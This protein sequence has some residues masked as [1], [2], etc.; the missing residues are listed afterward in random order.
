MLVS[1][2]RPARLLF[3]W[4]TVALVS[5]LSSRVAADVS[6]S[7]GPD[8]PH[9]T[10]R[11]AYNPGT[12]AEDVYSRSQGTRFSQLFPN[13]I[14]QYVPFP[15]S[16]STAKDFILGEL[17]DDTSQI[18]VFPLD[19][20][21]PGDMADYL[22]D[23][24]QYGVEAIKETIQ[25]EI[26]ANNS[27]KGRLVSL[28]WYSD[29]GLLY[30]RK[31]LLEQYNFTVPQTW[32][33]LEA[34]ALAILAGETAAGRGTN[35]IGFSFQ[36]KSYEGLTCN[37]LEWVAGRGGGEFVQLAAD[38]VTA[39]LT[40]NNPVTVEALETMRRFLGTIS[41]YDAVEYNEAASHAPFLAGNA[42][43]LRNWPYLLSQTQGTPVEGKF[44]VAYLPGGT[45]GQGRATLGGW[46]VGV[47]KRSRNVGFA[48]EYCKFLASPSEQA[49]MAKNL[50]HIPVLYASAM[51]D[52]ATL[53][54]RTIP[55]FCDLP[56]PNLVARPSTITAP[57]YG[58]V[59]T[60]LF[61]FAHDM[62]ASRT[63]SI[64]SRLNDVECEMSTATGFIVPR[65]VPTPEHV[66]P[67]NERAW[68]IGT[69]IA[70]AFALCFITILI[71]R[72]RREY[73]LHARILQNAK[74]TAEKASVM[75]SEFLAKSVQQRRKTRQCK[76]D[77]RSVPLTLFH[78]L[79]FL[80]ALFAACRTRFAHH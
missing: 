56:S 72:S 51:P 74:E 54:N 50:N 52:H 40:L 10:I 21:W 18:D 13:V 11:V 15:S 16:S 73:I 30:Y 80:C 62:L 64:Q 55:S 34:A 4:A 3:A 69:C 31:D 61:Q 46:G 59:S 17:I 71:C 75:K 7:T 58:A 39:T 44:G 66:T 36:A 27:P 65:C 33:E 48:V 5:L 41:P 25:Q 76:Q 78:A 8:L 79:L 67:L 23:L 45:A 6:S 28:P 1:L 26:L 49:F 57:N 22:I 77:S 37:F 24:N 19:V 32:A 47:S 20:V 35:L 2:R 53:C 60:L 70:V 14:V 12:V 9:T 38:N 68:F 63:L 42:I 29:F 43:F